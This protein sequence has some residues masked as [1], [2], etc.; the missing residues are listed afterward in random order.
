MGGADSPDYIM[1]KLG[2][3][4][5]WANEWKK[6]AVGQEQISV[7]HKGY[8]EKADEDNIPVNRKALQRTM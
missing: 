4:C 6:G 3:L 2:K 1:T 7:Q 5:L 8:V